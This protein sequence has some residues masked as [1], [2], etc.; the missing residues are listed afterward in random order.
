MLPAALITFREILEASLIVATILGILSKLHFHQSVKTV[1]IATASAIIVSILLLFMGSLVG[2]KIHDVFEDH[3]PIFE[4]SMMIISAFFVT[5]AVFFLHKTFAH[6]KLSLLQHVRSTIEKNEQ[7]GI[8]LLVFTA[9]FREGLE[10]V[11]FL[12]T[13]FFSNSTGSISLGVLLGTLSAISVAV[14]LFTAT[15]RLPVFQTFRAT[16]I[17]LILFAAGLLSQGIHELIEAQILP[18]FSNLPTLTLFFLPSATSHVGSIIQSIF[19]LSRSM[20][21]IELLFWTIY[22]WGMWNVTMKK[23][24]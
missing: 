13:L 19:G 16:S 10:I 8:F 23:S 11:L 4:G 21:S 6:H 24:F 18:T 12:S 5:W 17:L 9:V 7:K 3:E 14:L 1:W 15:I 2:V 22:A 20:P